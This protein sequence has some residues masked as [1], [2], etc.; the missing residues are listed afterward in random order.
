MTVNEH[1]ENLS[2]I[3]TIHVADY[4]YE[5]PE[6]RIAAYPLAERDASKLLIA[7]MR[8]HQNVGEVFEQFGSECVCRIRH[9]VFRDIVHE[10]PP[11]TLLVLNDT[12]V[13]AARILMKKEYSGGRAELICLSPVSPS[14]EP[15]I[16]LQSVGR[17]RWRCMIG[18]RNI[19]SG[20]ALV[21]RIDTESGS[22]VVWAVVLDKDGAEALVE[23]SWQPEELS[24]ATLL[25]MCGHVPLPPYIGRPEEEYDKTRYQTVY[26]AHDGSVAA[27]TAG[28]HFTDRVLE[29][30]KHRGVC[31]A[32]VTLHVG[33]GTFKPISGE[34]ARNHIMHEERICVERSVVESIARQLLKHSRTS[35]DPVVAVGTT[36]LRTLESLYWWGVRLIVC[37]GD[38]RES[39]TLD[40]RQWDGFRLQH[41][42][43]DKLPSPSVA[44]LAVQEWLQNRKLDTVR[45]DTQLMVV[46]GYAFKVCHGLITN[47]HQPQSTLMLLVAAFLSD[48]AQTHWHTVYNE[49]L[50][51]HYRFLSYGDASL[52]W[53]RE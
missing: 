49:A 46:P 24:F 32:Y 5:L 39:D 7:D 45:G 6:D 26:A 2:Y 37:D 40:I 9:S 15:A 18:G 38:A 27:P 41:C 31:I 35:Q 17:C 43:R 36:S 8:I 10:L 44:L 19:R 33:A 48:G 34:D 13:I 30:L 51:N 11:S 4:S 23:F 29:E 21:L 22:I 1:T 3:P 14:T 25:D 50:N 42:F 20:D 53:R 28:L 47:F 12:R 16:A 52:L